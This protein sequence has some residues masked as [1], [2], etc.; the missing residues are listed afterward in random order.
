MTQKNDPSGQPD[1]NY[2]TTAQPQRFDGGLY[3]KSLSQR[4]G[5][6]AQNN[7]TATGR[8]VVVPQGIPQVQDRSQAFSAYSNAGGAAKAKPDERSTQ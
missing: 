7:R 1:K 5:Y 8:Q 6:R 3:D 2:K 4:Q